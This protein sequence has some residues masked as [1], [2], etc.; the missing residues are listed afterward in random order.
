MSSKHLKNRSR[1]IF[2]LVK[3]YFKKTPT[4]SFPQYI[5]NE[6]KGLKKKDSK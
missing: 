5:G 3:E 4:M 6:K 1:V 2:K